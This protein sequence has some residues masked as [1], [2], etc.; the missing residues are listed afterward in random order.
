MTDNE[1]IEADICPE[2][3]ALLI[4]YDGCIRCQICAFALCQ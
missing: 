3:G 2:C 4:H 1:K